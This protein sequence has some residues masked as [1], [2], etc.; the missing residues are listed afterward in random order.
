[1]KKYYGKQGGIDWKLLA[2]IIVDGLI[3]WIVVTVIITRFKNPHMTDTQL[4][5]HIPKSAMLNFSDK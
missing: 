2:E 4:F 3:I 5:L 1:M